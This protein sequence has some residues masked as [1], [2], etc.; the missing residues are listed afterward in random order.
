MDYIHQIRSLTVDND[1]VAAGNHHK[2][3]DMGFV[4][5]FRGYFPEAIAKNGKNYVNFEL[6]DICFH[7]EDDSL[8]ISLDGALFLKRHQVHQLENK[9]YYSAKKLF[10]S[11]ILVP[12]RYSNRVKLGKV[13][14]QSTN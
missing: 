13:L 1:L 5:K 8:E 6:A 3:E 11:C 4:C 12:S 10:L 14:S 2:P 7:T 9:K